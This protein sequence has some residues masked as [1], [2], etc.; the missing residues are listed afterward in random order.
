MNGAY[1]TQRKGEGQLPDI[2]GDCASLPAKVFNPKQCEGGESNTLAV[3]PLRE[4]CPKCAIGP[5][6]FG[7]VVIG[8]TIRTLFFCEACEHSWSSTAYPLLTDAAKPK[9]A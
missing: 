1:Y 2:A 3:M 6:R 8:S 7:Q 4:S 9:T 5:V